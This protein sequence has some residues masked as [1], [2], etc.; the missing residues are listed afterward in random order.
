MPEEEEKYSDKPEKDNLPSPV[1]IISTIEAS[2]TAES[3]N[4][5]TQVP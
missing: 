4:I 3:G 2:D 5:V 1:L